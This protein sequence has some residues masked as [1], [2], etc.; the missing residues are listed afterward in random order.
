MSIVWTDDLSGIDWDE[1]SA[2]YRA[3]PL[4]DKA[5]DDLELVFR[6]SM[7]RAFAFD[8]G[9]LV[10][11]GRALADGRD[12]SYICDIA[13]HPSHQGRGLGKQIVA[14]LVHLSVQHRKIILY[15]VPGKESFY[16]S[17]GFRRMTTAMAIFDDPAKAYGR[18][19]L[20]D[21]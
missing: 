20:H 2:L 13:V 6:N 21:I 4:G 17:F 12:C 7:F 5:P 3:A 19:Y 8:S 10:G 1:L 16:E 14:R 15:A 11:A 18:G 9:A